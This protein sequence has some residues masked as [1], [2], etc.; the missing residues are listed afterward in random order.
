MN[1]ALAVYRFFLG[2]FSTVLI[3]Q[4]LSNIENL[5]PIF[6]S[7]CN[8]THIS[9]VIR[10]KRIMYCY[11]VQPALMKLHQYF[12][13]GK[14]FGQSQIF[15]HPSVRRR[16]KVISFQ[17]PRLLTLLLGNHLFDVLL[18]ITNLQKPDTVH[19]WLRNRSNRY[20]TTN[21][22]SCKAFHLY[23]SLRDLIEFH[24]AKLYSP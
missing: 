3:Y 7:P 13:S 23:I 17:K 2:K 11:V 5:I 4:S 21:Y 24:H 16:I 15:I 6:N 10:I 22:Q 18:G 9:K 14:I 20:Q 1:A 19:Q 8:T 12:W